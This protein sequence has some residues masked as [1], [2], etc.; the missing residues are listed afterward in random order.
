MVESVPVDGILHCIHRWPPADD[1]Q[2][3]CSAG[4][5]YMTE[6]WGP[7]D[8]LG[9]HL[10]IKSDPLETH[11]WHQT[12]GLTCSAGDTYMTEEW[13]PEDSL[14]WHLLIKKWPSGN[15]WLTS[16]WRP[17]LL[18]WGHLHDRGVGAGR[19]FRLTST[20]KKWPSGNTWLTSDWRPD[21][22]S[23]GHLHDRGVGA[24]RQSRLTSTNKKVTLWKHMTDIRLEAWPAQLETPTWQRSGGRK[25]V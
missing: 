21:L 4:D 3:T 12:G 22:L 5:T 24:G 20:N 15:T 17:D 11:D 6:E 14:G 7:E 9:W 1:L 13:G 16:D 8:S 25:T 23:W 2:C 19:Q 18:S 10:L